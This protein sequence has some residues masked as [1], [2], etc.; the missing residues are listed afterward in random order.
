MCAKK[1]GIKGCEVNDDPS[2]F[3]TGTMS[4]GADILERQCLQAGKVFIKAGEEI[5]R[6]Y[7]IQSGEVAAFV[8]EDGRKIEVGR[9]PPGTIIGEKYLVIEEP[10]KFSYEA[11]T[12]ATVATITRQDFQKRLARVDKSIKTVLDYAIQKLVYYENAEMAKALKHAEIDDMARGLVR[13]LLTGLSEEKR[14]RYENALLP[15][16]NGLIKD[17]KEIKAGGGEGE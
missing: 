15:H 3:E 17:I 12:T 6:A 16:I 14:D 4:K 9:F 7:I 13:S 10:S 8:E 11:V 2:L 5:I 1:Y